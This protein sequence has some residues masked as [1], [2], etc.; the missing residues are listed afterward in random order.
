MAKTRKTKR[1]AAP[2]DDDGSPTKTSKTRKTT[3]GAASGDNATAGTPTKSRGA[4]KTVQ[5]TTPTTRKSN[6]VASSP[7]KENE[8]KKIPAK[9]LPFPLNQKAVKE[10]LKLT[11]FPHIA[12]DLARLRLRRRIQK[13]MEMATAVVEGYGK[14]YEDR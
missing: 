14:Y 13:I 11:Y 1:S 8:K 12:S 5:K 4:T 9:H 2:G 6:R 10:R 7:S 3:R